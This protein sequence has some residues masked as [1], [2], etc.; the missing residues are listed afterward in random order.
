MKALIASHNQLYPFTH[1]LVD[2]T[3]LLEQSGEVLIPVPCAWNA[4]QEMQF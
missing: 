4:L 1:N 3:K 2:L